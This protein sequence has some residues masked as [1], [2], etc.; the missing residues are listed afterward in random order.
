KCRKV[1][2]F[3]FAGCNSSSATIVFYKPVAVFFTFSHEDC[4]E[5]IFQQLWQAIQHSGNVAELPTP[6]AVAVRTTLP[7]ILLI[8]PTHLIEK[9]S[10]F[11][12]VVVCGDDLAP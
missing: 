4:A 5:R 10:L 9:F 7:E 12:R 1:D 2:S 3:P 6:T 8:K 11:V